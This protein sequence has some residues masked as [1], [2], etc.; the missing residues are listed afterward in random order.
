[1]KKDKHPQYRDVL[2]EDSSNGAKFIVGSTIETEETTTF[3]GK[4]YPLYKVSVSSASH[5]FWTKANQFMDT[6]GR[7]DKF[8]KRYQKQQEKMAAAQSKI[9]E[10]KEEDKKKKKKKK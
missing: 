1:M 4:E 7:V 6:E 8:T 3:E 2:F 10:K 9:A 5:P